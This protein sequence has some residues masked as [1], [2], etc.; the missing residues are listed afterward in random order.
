MGTYG[1]GPGSPLQSQVWPLL[2][3]CLSAELVTGIWLSPTVADFS[4]PLGMADSCRVPLAPAVPSFVLG[5][6]GGS[7]TESSKAGKPPRVPPFR[8][9][10]CGGYPE[11]FR[12]Q[13]DSLDFG[14]Q[15]Q[16]NCRCVLCSHHKTGG[17]QL[18]MLQKKL[19]N[20]HGVAGWLLSSW[21]LFPGLSSVTHIEP[22]RSRPLASVIGLG[23]GDDR[24]Q[25]NQRE[26][27]LLL[28]DP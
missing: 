2:P 8:P 18:W 12:P 24:Q 26:K 23:R 5:T 10:W 27:Y 20:R 6:G 25:A 11:A 28:V 16:P 14:R 13:R 7:V 9:A 4:F 21:H 15:S 19:I 22:T 1:C 17:E 3:G